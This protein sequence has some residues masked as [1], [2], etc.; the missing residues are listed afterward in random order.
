FGAVTVFGAKAPP[1]W[2][3]R[4]GLALQRTRVGQLAAST[5]LWLKGKRSFQ[6]WEGM[7]MFS[8]ARVGPLDPKREMVYANFRGNLRD[9]LRAGLSSPTRIILNKV[10]VNLRDCPPFA[11]MPESDPEKQKSQQAN[12]YSAQNQFGL[13]RSSLDRTNCA[14]ARQ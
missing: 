4:F 5:G 10:A 8:A 12:P 11:S 1:L 2:M 9:I 14:E 13:A 6:S 3:V 7:Q